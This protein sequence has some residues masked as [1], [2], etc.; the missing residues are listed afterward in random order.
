[1]RK[2]LKKSYII[3]DIVLLIFIFV[4]LLNIFVIKNT[5]FFFNGITTLITFILL[6]IQFGYEFKA[7]RFKQETIFYIITYT[8]MFIVA[9]YII[10][11]FTGFAKS[12]Y[13]FS[14][15][16]IFINILPYT[17]LIASGELLRSQV[18]RK[19]EKST[20]SYTLCAIALT[21]VDC[22]IY[23]ST[24]NL[25]TGDGQIQ[26]IC[27]ILLPS[28]S[29]NIFLL[30][31]STMGGLIPT[32]IYRL[33]MELKIFIIPIVP[34]FGLY[35]DSVVQTIIPG[36]IGIII[37]INLK[38]FQN[39]EVEGK[40]YKQGLL[41]SYASTIIILM[42]IIL[43]VALTSCKFKYGAIAIGSGSM[44]GT[45]NKGDVV[46]FKQ[47]G[48]YNPSTNEIVVFRKDGKLI[49]HRIIETVQVNEE[50]YI[51]YTKGDANPTADGY[52]LTHDE[53]VGTVNLRIK[54]IGIPSVYLHELLTKKK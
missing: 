28:V 3:I 33:L 44:T 32:I 34:D 22:T 11:I 36:I 23:L 37:F 43:I 50:E 39:K 29:K 27:N 46:V 10:G 6:V 38:Q 15:K 8:I 2:G 41:Y 49:V 4:L 26:F 45:I 19:C 18:T 13:V 1:M 24:F 25:A 20:L 52:P 21:L 31:I 53:L 7:K 35:I 16:G 51:Y 9:T 14:L 54:Y 47:I 12:I 40:S 30:Y 5:N 42:I 17:L 48:N